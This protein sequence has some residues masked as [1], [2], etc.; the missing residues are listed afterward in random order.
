MASFVRALSEKDE[1][2]HNSKIRKLNAST[3]N[4]EMFIA[5]NVPELGKGDVLLAK[6]LDR[7]IAGKSGWHFQQS[8]HCS[9]LM[10]LL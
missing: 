4:D 8:K 6:D 2:K 3:A 9:E 1:I 7:K 5:V 10:K